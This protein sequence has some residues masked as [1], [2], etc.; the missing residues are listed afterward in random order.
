MIDTNVD[1]FQWPFRRIEGDDP[2]NLV[3]NLRKKG[4]TQAWAGSFE[5]LIYRD[6]AG[7]NARLA[8]AAKQHG[9]N[10]LIP[11]GSI[12]P[13]LPD[14]QEDVRRCVEVHKMP[15]IRLH[16]NYHGYALD[17]P[18]AG[19]LLA[20]AGS[21][22]LLVQIAISMEDIRTQSP[23][24]IIH[25]VDPGP[26]FDIV[27]SA[28][29]LRIELL[30]AG[31][32]GGVNTQHIE[33]MK[34]L[35]NIYFDFACLESVGGVARLVEQTSPKRVLFGSHYPFFYFESSYLKVYEAR[36]PAEQTQAILES[37]ARALL[38]R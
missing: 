23:L 27:K 10:F 21:K 7:V 29:N 38:G 15:G 33:D 12:N 9:P 37:N 14:W 1:L 25:P 8:A 19:E 22:N 4:V 16:P 26:L 17:D 35:D 31:Y 3:A 6:M 11:F 32:H 28:P 2:A 34:K 36:L 18:E 20:L 5:G 30:N 13:K 24:M